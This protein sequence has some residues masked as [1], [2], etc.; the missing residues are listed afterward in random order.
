MQNLFQVIPPNFFNYL[1]SNSNGA[2][3]SDC[4]ELIYNEYE[5]EIS[6]RL[7][8]S[9][10]RD[11]LAIYLLDHHIEMEEE[12]QNHAGQ[13]PGD[14]ASAILRRLSDPA[15]GWLE[16]END[17]ATYEK[18]ILM[19][20]QGIALAEFLSALKRPERE[21]YAGYIFAIYNTLRNREQ[22]E[23]NPYVNGLRVVYRN[24]KLLSQSL[25][26]LST[27]IRKYIERVTREESLESLTDHLMEYCEGSFIREYARL[28]KQQNI[29]IYRMFIREQLDGLLNRRELYELLITE[30]AIEEGLEEEEQR[31]EEKVV[32][33]VHATQR[34][35]TQDYD[36]IMAGIKQKISLYMQLALARARFLRNREADL[37]GGVE[38]VLKQLADREELGMKEQLPGEL[39]ALFSLETHSFL[40]TTSVHYPGRKN[41]LTASTVEDYRPASEEEKQ[42]AKRQQEREAYNPYA[43]QRMKRFLTR[44][45]GDRSALTGAE[46]PLRSRNDLLAAL[47]A[48]AYGGEN[49]FRIRVEEDYI[50]TDD[51][52]LRNFTIE[53]EEQT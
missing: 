46:L 23:S 38:Q 17:E 35:L 52:S 3:Y 36:R 5:Q 33:M 48:V 22:W 43:R 20:E 24:A 2:V 12:E 28:T 21:E 40:N 30:C 26:R 29:H 8:R 7:P 50:E 18:Q 53:K 41:A 25:K 37:R 1:A 49:G 19:T 15:V 42:A 13:T 11:T 34:F 27:F 9:R 31:A 4:L 10:I 6:Y 14:Q 44:Q 39:A 32:D 51:L 47:S 16:E 45:M